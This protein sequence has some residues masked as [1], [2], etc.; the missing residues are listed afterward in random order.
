VEAAAYT[1]ALLGRIEFLFFKVGREAAAEV[2][3]TVTLST[4]TA[5]VRGREFTAVLTDL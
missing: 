5:A 4:A 2:L 1:G 3:P